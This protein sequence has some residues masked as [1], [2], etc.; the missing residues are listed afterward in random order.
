[1]STPACF[2]GIPHYLLSGRTLQTIAGEVEDT[3]TG[4]PVSG[5]A[6]VA[7]STGQWQDRSTVTDAEGRFILQVEPDL[8]TLQVIKDEY[9]FHDRTVLVSREEAL[10]LPLMRS[11]RR[12]TRSAK[13]DLLLVFDSSVR[14]DELRKRLTENMQWL[15]S[16]LRQAIGYRDKGGE[17]SKDAGVRPDVKRAGDGRVLQNPAGYNPDSSEIAALDLRIGIV[18]DGLGCETRPGEGSTVT[19][20]GEPTASFLSFVDPRSRESMN[21]PPPYPWDGLGRSAGPTGWAASISPWGGPTGA[22]LQPLVDEFIGRLNCELGRMKSGC[23]I[24]QPLEA[25]RAAL[26]QHRPDFVRSG[27]VLVVLILSSHDDCSLVPFPPEAPPGDSFACFEQG[28]NCDERAGQLGAHHGCRPFGRQL[29]NVDTY[30][31][32]FDGYAENLLRE[33][34][35]RFF[36]SVIAGVP[37]SVSVAPDSSGAFALSSSCS[38]TVFAEPAIRLYQVSYGLGARGSFQSVCGDMGRALQALATRIVNATLLSD[39]SRSTSSR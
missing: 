1:M 17:A 22:W 25:A 30:V 19:D 34:Q 16:A 13:V 2:D 31:R 11:P 5:A 12:S 9:L 14:R 26:E 7:A 15:T 32:F 33:K 8:W 23:P 3:C 24:G 20:C 27:S 35:T 21:G 18:G 10:K 29:E 38:T 6:V 37:G 36:L 39:C 28:I 4:L